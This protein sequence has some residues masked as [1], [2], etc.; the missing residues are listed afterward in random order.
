MVEIQKLLL[1]EIDNEEISENQAIQQIA[2]CKS[3]VCKYKK[4]EQFKSVVTGSKMFVFFYFFSDYCG[5]ILT[6]FSY[7]I[8]LLKLPSD[9]TEQVL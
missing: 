7:L 6:F 5:T 9:P 8:Y 2:V 3:Y 4:H 1:H